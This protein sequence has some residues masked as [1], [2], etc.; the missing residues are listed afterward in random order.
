MSPS[1]Q[2][3]SPI[4][5]T[6]T[7]FKSAKQPH[8][9][10]QPRTNG[11]DETSSL[12]SDWSCISDDEDIESVTSSFSGVSLTSCSS[13][14]SWRSGPSTP[15]PARP[16]VQTTP[17][18]ALDSDGT[19]SK[20]ERGVSF[21]EIVAIQRTFS[22]DDYD[23]TSI[24]PEPLSQHD[25]SLLLEYREEMYVQTRELYRDRYVSEACQA[26]QIRGRRNAFAVYCNSPTIEAYFASMSPRGKTP[27][28][29]QP[30]QQQYPERYRPVSNVYE[31]PP[32]RRYTSSPQQQQRNN[33]QHHLL[34]THVSLASCSSA[35]SSNRR[36][37]WSP[38]S[39]STTTPSSSIWGPP[40]TNGNTG[41]AQRWNA[42]NPRVSTRP[43]STYGGL[44]MN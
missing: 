17:S 26:A 29:Q 22:P 16:A 32:S 6:S 36:S 38:S 18:P 20:K 19:P 43:A 11:D 31:Q 15:V 40:A 37:S 3:I 23:R 4:P 33:G 5:S 42:F 44:S 2:P 21:Y 13:P 39:A 24:E 9:Q 25:I 14:L 7:L 41:N 30:Q 34:K 28:P 35:S 27:Q 12:P 1:S 10:Q 8:Q